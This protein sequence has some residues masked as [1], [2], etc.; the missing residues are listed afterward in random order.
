MS[1]RPVKEDPDNRQLVAPGYTFASVTDRISAVITDRPPLFWMIMITIAYS[2]QLV[3]W[4]LYR[5]G[6]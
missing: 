5:L 6:V 4:L 2:V 1:A 3:E